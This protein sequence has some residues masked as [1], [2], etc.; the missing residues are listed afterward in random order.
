MQYLYIHPWWRLSEGCGKENEGNMSKKKLDI[1]AARACVYP[2]A[3]CGSPGRS[4][5]CW[6]QPAVASRRVRRP[7]E[8]DNTTT[9]KTYHTPT[10]Y[11]DASAIA[12]E[13]TLKS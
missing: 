13:V 3:D 4:S 7:L 8:H 10:E 5:K 1:D 2:I 11:D 12:Y 6:A 9:W